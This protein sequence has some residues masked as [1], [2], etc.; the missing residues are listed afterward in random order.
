MHKIAGD[1]ALLA[2]V[3]LDAALG[4]DFGDQ[5]FHFGAEP[6]WRYGGH[7]GRIDTQ[8]A[9]VAQLADWLRRA[10]PDIARRRRDHGGFHH[11]LRGLRTETPKACHHFDASRRNT[12][13][14]QPDEVLG[15]PAA[16]TSCARSRMAVQKP[17]RGAAAG[18]PMV[19][20]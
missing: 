17:L 12:R 20:A 13:P 4:G 19:A 16:A 15:R 9:Q 6:V 18:V 2:A 10:G 7:G 3:K 1:L 11:R 5:A 8:Q 14:N